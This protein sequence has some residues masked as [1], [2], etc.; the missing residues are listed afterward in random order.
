MDVFLATLASTGYP[1]K[2][3]PGYLP[4]MS[5]LLEPVGLSQADSEIYLRLLGQGASTAADLSEQTRVPV[6]RL[7][8]SLQRLTE[9]GLANRIVSSPPRYVPTPPE[10]A[11][12]A[13]VLHRQ[14]TL[15]ELRARAR[16][17]ALNLHN[18]PI[19]PAELVELIEGHDALFS[20]LTRL[21]LGARDEVV[22]IDAPPYINSAV[23][24]NEREIKA[25]ERGVTY[26]CIYHAPILTQSDRIFHLA[27]YLAAGEKARV[28][29]EIRMK[30][31]IADRRRALIPLSF[32]GAQQSTHLLVHPSPL[33][34]ALIMCFESLW[35]RATPM[36]PDGEVMTTP[37]R[38]DDRDR[39]IL[40]LLAA[41]QKDAAIGR[42]IGVTQRTVVRRI[43][44]LMRT[45]D[46]DTRFQAGVQAARRG[47]L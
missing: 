44:E 42:A 26:R 3:C 29:P 20:T 8:R 22:M 34:D 25:L 15:D 30:M 21:E 1:A 47:W 28:L 18:E 46:A 32:Q 7:R 10:V 14:Q 4:G 19:R 13:L 35:E 33:L 6:A 5:H 12:D 17:L 2:A 36:A 31:M 11:V 23:V 27:K 40:R 39:A 41:G 24:L 45:L 37:E 16:D 38:I 9:A 43:A